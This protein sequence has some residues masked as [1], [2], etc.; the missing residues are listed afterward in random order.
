LLWMVL[1]G[2]TKPDVGREG[3]TQ[4]CKI[5][6]RAKNCGKSNALTSRSCRLSRHQSLSCRVCWGRDDDS[7]SVFWQRKARSLFKWTGVQLFRGRYDSTLQAPNL[8]WPRRTNS[9]MSKSR[10]A[11]KVNKDV[12]RHE[13]LSR[14]SHAS[15]EDLTHHK[16]VQPRPTTHPVV[17]PGRVDFERLLL[18]IRCGSTCLSKDSHSSEG[19][20]WITP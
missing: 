15:S 3:A 6:S 7:C 16:A 5:F 18:G 14:K 20:L 19:R 9:C 4:R 12:S 13:H 2:Q 1:E 11:E 10:S 8:T 17:V